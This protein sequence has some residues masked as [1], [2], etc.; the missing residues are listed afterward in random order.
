[1]SK[2]KLRV[3]FDANPIV[4]GNKSGVGYYT[5]NLITALAENYPNDIQLTGHYFSFLGKKDA[6]DLP[7]ASNITYIR[8]RFIPGKILS[9]TRMLGLQPPLELFFRRKGDLALFTNFVSLPSLFRTPTLVTVHDLCFEDVPEYVAEKNRNFLHRFVPQAVKTASKVITI[10]QS[11]QRAIQ[12]KYGTPSEK[13]IVTPIPPEK[14]KS[15]GKVKLGTMGVQ[16]KF[17]LFV[18]TLEPRK[19]IIGLVK[20]YAALPDE[21]KKEYALVL[22]GGNGWY[23]EETLGY[24]K[25]LQDSGNNIVLT[26]YITDAQKSSLYQSADLFVLPSH[27]EGFGMPILEAMSY[28]VPT[29]VSDIDVFHE[30]SGNASL[31]FNHKDPGAIAQSI[32][33]LL[34]NQKLLAEYAQKGEERAAS[35]SWP[36]VART[37]YDNLT[38]LNDH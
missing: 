23:I 28:G 2:K 6:A 11:T 16:G 38:K 20:A 19:N 35:Y 22:A 14:H 4:N 29:A 17:I 8:S 12:N 25:Q 1:M 15:L 32:S 3:L 13:F 36:E 34:T 10:S 7:K 27:Y 18:G 24:I 5:Y 9:I 31:Y 26:G 33:K 30:V 21:I 37:L